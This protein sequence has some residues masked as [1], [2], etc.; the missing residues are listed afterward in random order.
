MNLTFSQY[1]VTEG[2]FQFLL[3][4]RGTQYS[5]ESQR[6]LDTSEL[7]GSSYYKFLYFIVPMFNEKGLVKDGKNGSV[8][9]DFL[10]NK[11]LFT[12]KCMS[13]FCILSLGYR[14]KG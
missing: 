12:C 10:E 13:T 14:G 4:F 3:H 7:L 5:K 9:E 2:T 6:V 8:V 11:T 1:K